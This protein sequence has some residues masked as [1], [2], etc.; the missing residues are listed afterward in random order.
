[1]LMCGKACEFGDEFA[2]EQLALVNFALGAVAQRLVRCGIQVV[3]IEA[4]DP[5]MDPTTAASGEMTAASIG[6]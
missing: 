4:E 3:A 1:M 2:A 5:A 6:R